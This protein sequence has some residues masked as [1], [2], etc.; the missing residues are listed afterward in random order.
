MDNIKKQIINTFYYKRTNKKTSKDIFNLRR[1]LLSIYNKEENKEL[2][3]YILNTFKD[4]YV[5]IE[6]N[7]KE[8][9]YRI[10]YDIKE[11]PK[12]PICGKRVKFMGVDGYSKTC[13]EKCHHKLITEKSKI[14]MLKHQNLL[15][16]MHHMSEAQA[17]LKCNVSEAQAELINDIN[18][19]N[20]KQNIIISKKYDNYIKKVMF[21]KNCT[22]WSN[23]IR[24]I[25]YGRIENKYII[26]KGRMIKHKSYPNIYNYL[27]YRYNDIPDDMFSIREVILRIKYNIEK[28]PVCPHCKGPINFV[29][30]QKRMYGDFCSNSCRSSEINI[31]FWR[32]AI[33]DYRFGPEQ[34]A[35]REKTCM[36]KYGVKS[37]FQLKSV[38]EKVYKT[39][40]HNKTFKKSK[41]EDETYFKLISLFGIS[42]IER[43]YKSD[44]YPFACDF[45]VK[46]LDLYIECNYH[47]THGTHPFDINNKEDKLE[48]EKLLKGNIKKYSSTLDVWCKRDVKK[49]NIAKKNNLNYLMFYSP[50]E[51]N[52]WYYD[53][54]MSVI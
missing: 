18:S 19:V 37:T 47:W 40:Q 51:F 3:S 42:D 5:N 9:L 12:C 27:K 25:I 35:K 41:Q 33:K 2:K 28:R 44:L 21:A 15:K 36:E 34:V 45:Y 20:E 52:D 38:Q 11:I 24:Y 31:K 53:F 50:K 4:Y 1:Y 30:K 23:R 32:E 17:E 8:I 46:S 14:T 29:G 6:D 43:Q 16:D 10:K 7:L 49:Y 26:G 48:Y 39:K 54:G 22:L 13:S